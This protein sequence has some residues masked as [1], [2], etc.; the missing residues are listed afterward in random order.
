MNAELICNTVLR[1]AKNEIN[2]YPVEERRDI[3]G[4]VAG[5]LVGCGSQL[6]NNEVNEVTNFY[7]T[8]HE[9]AS[10]MIFDKINNEC[11]INTQLASTVA[12]NIYLFRYKMFFEPSVLFSLTDILVS[13]GDMFL[14]KEAIRSIENV[15]IETLSKVVSYKF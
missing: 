8:N 10:T 3:L 5:Y 6:P 12:R 13:K 14:P 15:G 1:F 2:T 11:F 4:V 9:T 7:I